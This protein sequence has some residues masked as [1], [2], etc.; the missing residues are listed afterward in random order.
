MALGTASLSDPKMLPTRSFLL[1]AG[2]CGSLGLHAEHVFVTQFP[3]VFQSQWEGMQLC[4][5]LSG[6]PFPAQSSSLYG[7]I[8]Q[9]PLH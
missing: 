5:G 7:M 3:D 9:N 4:L 6:F 2:L 8:Q 1:A